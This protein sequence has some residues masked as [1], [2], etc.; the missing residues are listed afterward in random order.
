MTGA[1]NPPAA[2]PTTRLRIAQALGL[3]ALVAALVGAL[4]PAER[5]RTMYSWPPASLP[6]DTPSRVWY[7]PVLLIT[8]EPEILSADVPC[9]LPP[10]L[11]SGD[12]EL[13]LATAR[14]PE[15]F[16]GLA[17]TQSPQQLVV[18]LGRDVL[19][20]VDLPGEGG[21]DD[22]AHRVTI[23]GGGWS[24]SGG[25]GIERQGAVEAM[26]TVNGLFTALDLRSSA[27][28]SV[29][30]TTAPHAT[31]TTLRQTLAWIVAALA[32][33]GALLLVAIERRPRHWRAAV[34]RRVR[35]GI[36]NAHPADAVVAVALLGWCVI[37]PVNFDDGWVIQREQMFD[38]SKGFSTYYSNLGVNLPLDYWLEWVHHWLA[39]V[40]TALIVFRVP[41]FLVLMIVWLLCRWI[42]SQIPASAVREERI[43]TWILAC[44]FILGS[45][46]WGMTMRPEPV[47]ALFVTGVAACMVR[48]LTRESAAPVAL[49]SAL[50]ALALTAHPA[51]VVSLASVL[52]AAP[53]LFRWARSRLAPAV[54]IVSASSALL[55]TLAFVGSDLDQRLTD[56]ETTQATSVPG[57]DELQRYAYLWEEPF[58]TPLR[59]A[60]VVLVL[61]AVAAFVLRQE[62]TRRGLL[63]FPAWALAVGLVLLVATPSKWPSH[64]GALIGIGGLAIAAE[65]ARLRTDGRRSTGWQAWPLLAIAAAF[66]AA[67]WSWWERDSWNPL[68]LRTLDWESNFVYRF[69]LSQL[70]VLLPVLL[71]AASLVIALARGQR[72][73]LYRVPWRVASWI[74][75]A[76]A[77][78]VLLFTVGVLVVDA[79]KTS[80]WTVTRQNL[81]TVAGDAGCG[82]AD[83]V[84]V[85]RR[86][87]ARPLGIV[88]PSEMQSQPAWV[89]QGP[90]GGLPRFV[91]GPAADTLSYSPWFELPADRRAGL[92]VTGTPGPSDTLWI[93]WGRTGGKEVELLGNSEIT[94]VVSE[95]SGNAPWRF[96]SAGDLPT[97]HPRATAVRIEYQAGAV[98]GVALAITSPVTY[99]NERLVALMDSESSRT[100]VYPELYLYFPCT[101]LPKLRNG[102]VEVPQHVVIGETESPPLRYHVTSPFVGLLDLYEL[103]RVPVA[104]SEESVDRLRVFAVEQRIPGAALAP[105]IAADVVS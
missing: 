90:V 87:S 26:P 61:L 78:P 41:V 11:P 100:L 96:F 101:N 44:A 3:L 9:R 63:D 50:A 16:G 23:A 33:I 75:A 27:G 4:G 65:A 36:A 13:V 37:A 71:L 55:A 70:G 104:D 83:D 97:A 25:N 35:N 94:E 77:I 47:T 34:I 17:I 93:K 82:L 24:I 14:H 103:E 10:T 31:R 48:F 62:R 99:S 95:L 51:G 54:T 84:L 88:G 76:V 12:P 58:G 53:R 64:F 15:R 98:P 20:R 7:A 19:D 22:C 81:G 91:L 21:R 46:A 102:I 73:E 6:A 45:F 30:V 60:F 89:P 1:E 79:A 32:A 80:S 68:D 5:V 69:G 72:G 56:A 85:P 49:A 57:R 74:P 29:D 39:E 40:S 92:F 2:S 59:R 52:V 42:A 43:N 66:L 67:T 86:D 28:F 8:H 38:S 18:S 105:P